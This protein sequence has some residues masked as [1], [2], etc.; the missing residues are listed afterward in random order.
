[1]ATGVGLNPNRPGHRCEAASTL[2]VANIDWSAP[3]LADWRAVGEPIAQ[4][5]LAGCPQSQALSESGW[6]SVGF[7]P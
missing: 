6:S 3:W 1:M 7:V 4:R 2:G 5:V